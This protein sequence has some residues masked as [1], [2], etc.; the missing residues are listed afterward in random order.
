MEVEQRLSKARAVQREIRANAEIVNR[1]VDELVNEYS[2]E[3]D[4]FIDIVKGLLDKIK[5]RKIEYSNNVLELQSI[6][7]PVLMYYA[8]NGLE[9][10]GAEHDIA[11]AHKKEMYSE[12][13]LDVIGTIP[14]RDAKATAMVLTEEM[15]EAVYS[16]A[17]K[18]LKLKIDMADKLF[19]ALKKVLSKRI[20]EIDISNRDNGRNMGHEFEEGDDDDN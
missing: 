20:Q 5:Q 17:Y 2:A 7:L 11:K 18:K 14:E 19:S 16:R 8:G 15:M 3:L 13:Y 12:K 10:L 4:D 1:L 6:K 9:R